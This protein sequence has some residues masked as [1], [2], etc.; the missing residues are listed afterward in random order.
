LQTL[1]RAISE[2]QPGPKW[3]GLF[4]EYWPAYQ[5]WWLREGEGERA[6]YMESRRALRQHMPELVPLY[7]ELCGLAGGGDQAARF[8]SFYCPPPYLS[9][10]SQAIWPGEE[11]VM[12]RN[13]D[14]NPAAFDSLI[15]H[16]NWLGRKVM[17]TSDG[18]WGLVD[19]VNDAGLAIS[20]TFGG[21][22]QVGDG[23]GVPLILR[24][25]LQTCET[26]DEAGEVLARIPTHM[27][28]NVTAIDARR[29]Y[30]TVQM[31]PD[32]PS[33][34]TNAAVATNHQS[35]VEW[36]SHARFTSTVE[37]ERY[38]LQRLTLHVDTQ[39]R[40]I[41][42]F[43]KPPLYSTAYA[44]GFGTLYTAVYRPRQRG[45]EIR[46]PGSTWQFS[47]D[48]FRPAARRIYTPDTAQS[49]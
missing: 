21:R 20:L 6:T 43:L 3:A 14:Y 22:R 32:R 28:Y 16:S 9:G 31:A 35:T 46:W 47:L 4:A 27:S 30:V 36:D 7:D 42:A 2:A 40:F 23:F 45:M 15:L 25:V 24:Y 10:C 34:V 29:K 44:A 11:P 1:W 39:H 13:Y 18:L 12:V 8:L 33:L 5:R 17:G 48:N 41:G 26:A 38:L 19:G 49:G 37:R